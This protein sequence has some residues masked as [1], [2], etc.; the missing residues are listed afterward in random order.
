MNLAMAHL[1]F[2][3]RLILRVLIAV[4]SA[5]YI[6]SLVP[7]AMFAALLVASGLN[8]LSDNLKTAY[9]DLQHKEFALVILHIGLTATL[10]MLSAVVLGEIEHAVEQET[11]MHHSLAAH[12]PRL[13]C[14]GMLFT[15]T[16]FIVQYSSVSGVLQSATSLLERSKVTR[17]IAEQGARRIPSNDAQANISCSAFTICRVESCL[18]VATIPCQ[19]YSN[20]TVPQYSS[21]IYTA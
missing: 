15:A 16:I 20:S 14:T 13:V 11:C 5:R 4:I 19:T 21:S 6:V 9:T 12:S 2:M 10:G 18:V 7:K 17:T 1:A 8:L 3:H